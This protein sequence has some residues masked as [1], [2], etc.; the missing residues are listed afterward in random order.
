MTELQGVACHIGSH[1]VT[2]HQTHANTP[3]S[4]PSH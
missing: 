4:N 2:C 3:Y 1:R